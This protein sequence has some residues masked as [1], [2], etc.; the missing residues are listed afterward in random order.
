MMKPKGFPSSRPAISSRH[1]STGHLHLN[2]QITRGSP[3]KIWFSKPLVTGLIGAASLIGL[4]LFFKTDIQT[5]FQKE[6]ILIDAEPGPIKIRPEQTDDVQTPHK[7]KTI[8]KSLENDA[9]L[10]VGEEKLVA[11]PEDPMMQNPVLSDNFFNNFIAPEVINE[12]EEPIEL[13]DDSSDTGI[14]PSL[15]Y[16]IYQLYPLKSTPNSSASHVKFFVHLMSPVNMDDVERLIKRIQSNTEL[17]PLILAYDKNPI[18]VDRG[19]KMGVD[20]RLQIGPLQTLEEGRKICDHLG[21]YGC[22]VVTEKN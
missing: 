11:Q 19:Q 4:G 6:I 2:R 7:E 9:A 16:K 12:Q 17:A 22:M 1:Q 8:Y 10:M 14:M 5:Y 3:Q 20:Y 13:A 15:S 21:M 18:I